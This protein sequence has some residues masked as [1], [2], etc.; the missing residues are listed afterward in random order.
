MLDAEGLGRLRAGEG[1][2]KEGILSKI[3]FPSDLKDLRLEDLELLA[4]EVRDYIVRIVSQTGG[5]LAPS[6]GVVELTIALLYVFDPPKDKI[7]WDVGHQSYVYKILTGRRRE[8][9][10]LRQRGGISGFPK[11]SES[12][13]D[14]FGTGHA[15]TAISAALGM[16]VGR[17]LK[18]ENFK[19]VAV[20]GD[21]SLTGGLSWEGLNHAGDE[22]RDLVVVLNDNEFSISPT[23]G[24]LSHYLS[25]RLADPMYLK[26]REEVK[27]HL[28]SKPGGD[29]LLSLFKRAEESFKSFFT[30]GVLFEELGFRYVG[31]V[32]GHKLKELVS[33]FKQVKRAKEPILVHVLTKKG[34]GYP[35]AEKDPRRFHGVGPFNIKTGKPKRQEG[36]TYTKAFS[37]TAVRLAERNEKIVAITAAMPDGTGL[38]LFADRFPD[39]FFDVGIAEQHA[40]VFAAGL[41]TQGLRPLCAIYSTFLQRAYD[42]IV[43]DVALQELPVVF[44]L[45]RAGIVGEDG[46]THHGSFDLSYLRHIPNMVVAAPKDEAELAHLLYTAFQQNRPFAL[47]YPKGKA[48]GVGLPEEFREM[49]IGKGEILR[50][51]NDVAILAVGNMVYRSLEAARQLERQGVSCLVINARFVKPLDEELI[52]DAVSTCRRVITVE[53]NAVA[54]G[55]GSGVWELLVSK[56]ASFKGRAM[57]IPDS[58]VSHGKADELRKELG[59]SPEGIAQAVLDLLG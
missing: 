36:L 14:S 6:L 20:V 29:A 44:A 18:R 41:A 3:N 22:E 32:R 45:D 52:L 40:V 5:H 23:S 47:R 39:R 8:F 28:E 11:P 34:K 13:Y 53:E 51:G 42:Q 2:I 25:R 48:E 35:P 38:S 55:F 59:L 49:E 50:E 10:T 1:Q 33:T 58:F 43:H 37:E 30:P 31:P 56:G 15:C 21:G 26:L 12:E 19:V 16:A 17:D 57:G 54:G 9:S 4:Q 46:P 7:V 24:A 27:R